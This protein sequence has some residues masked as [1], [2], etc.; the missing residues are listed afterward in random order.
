M[1]TRIF[2]KSLQLL[3]KQQTNILSAAFV[4]M[5]TVLLSQVLGLIRQRLLVATFGASNTAGTYL[6]AT[7]WPELLF[8]LIIAG[9][10]S[11][12][13]IPVFSQYLYK[14]K[15][16]EGH[17][18]A[19]NLLSIGL[20]IFIPLAILIIIF[21]DFFAYIS[22]P[23]LDAGQL[24]MIATMMRIM[25]IGQ[26]L[27]IIASFL[28]AV[29]QSY[30][31]FF[32]PG[33]AL[34]LY[35]L[36]IIIGILTL[37]HSIGIY[38]AAWGVVIG[39]FLYVAI[40][41][42]FMKSVHFHYKFLI[43]LANRGV[44]EVSKLMW[45]RTISLTITQLGVFLLGAIVSLVHDGARNYLLFDYAQILAFAPVTLLGVTIAQASFPVL[46]RQKEN[47][48]EF[49]M[50]F[51]TSFNQMLYLILPVSVLFLVLRIPLV[52]L[53]YGASAVDWQATVLTGRTVAF[54]S[55]SIFAQALL[56][57]VLRAF[58]A[59]HDTKIPL[60][61]S[62]I[63]TVLMIIFSYL[64]V[65]IFHWGI[66]GVALSFSVANICNLCV[67]LALLHAKTGGFFT[68]QFILSIVKIF[69][70]SFF[71]AFAL[72]IPIKLLDRLVF[73]TTK[74]VNLLILTGISSAIGTVLYLFLTWLFNVHE[75]STYVLLFRKIGNWR[76]ILGSSEEPVE[77]T[78]TTL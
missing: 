76:A 54:F 71:T 65:T 9:A 36:G 72:Y 11:S 77:G 21:A 26:L 5:S 15:I 63:T 23:G 41:L 52:R 45:P 32:I 64:S 10:L 16:D 74:T 22:A 24:I 18:F 2:Q 3:T 61:V 73:D 49:N 30:N 7:R 40:Q 14:G 47:K 34:S 67:L 56:Q 60:I 50:T 12:A 48:K 38:S 42:P 27:F 31:R 44:R 37:S 29:L 28:S 4:L 57:L 59:L 43:T 25:V 68:K 66:I 46:S 55:I 39:A 20:G 78:T 13:F 19:S 70:A 8:Q 53:V 33:I 75:A 6:Y 17:E 51:I 35:N 1:P 69:T 62:G 58:Y